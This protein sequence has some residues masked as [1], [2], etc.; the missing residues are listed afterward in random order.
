MLPLKPKTISSKIVTICLIDCLILVVLILCLVRHSMIALEEEVIED[1]LETDLAY[2]QCKLGGCENQNWEIRDGYLYRGDVRLGNGVEA[3]ANVDPFMEFEKE[4]GTFGFSGL[5]VPDNGLHRND[6]TGNMQGHYLR[7]AGSTKDPDG[8][9]II[10]TYVDKYV[11][12]GLDKEGRFFGNSNVE[13]GMIYSLY[14]A[15]YNSKHEITGFVVVGRAASE[16]YDQVRFASQNILVLLIIIILLAGVGIALVSHRWTKGISKIV[17]YLGR[18]GQNEFPEDK[19]VVDSRDETEDIAESINDMV[20][21]LKTGKRIGVELSLASDIQAHM[22]PCIFPPY[23]DANEFDVFASMTPAKEVGG[24][25]YDFF[26]LD[27]KNIAVVIADVSGKGIPSALVMVIAKTLIKNH[28]TYGLEPAEVFTTVNK[29]LC[30]GNDNCMFVTA[31]MGVLNTE[32]GKLTYVNAGHN[33]PLIKKADGTFEYLTSKAEFVLAGMEGI[34]YR[35]NVLLMEPGSRLFLYTDGV[36]EATNPQEELYGED[37]L[38]DFLNQHSTEKPTELL[39][40]LKKNIDAFA[41]E[42]EQF[43]DMTMLVLDYHKR[44]SNRVDA[45]EKTFPA[46]VDVLPDATAFLEEELEKLECSS[47]VQMQLSIA[48]EELFVNIAHYAY[49]GV[50]GSVRM[51]ISDAGENVVIQ[52]VDSGIPFNPLDKEDPNITSSAEEREIGGLGIFLAKKTADGVDYEY[53]NGQNILTMT[54]KKI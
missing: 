45:S 33:H 8:K 5:R 50:R 30:E 19:L 54:K 6:I 27:E 10:G 31:W 4:T 26:M 22:L 3:E 53:K 48:L 29:M 14:Y 32:T 36:T 1:R 51:S 2:L 41:G 47:K 25:F 15:T 23:P 9:S 38:R 52:L 35:Q 21:A 24:D 17:E 12:D 37:R 13:G 43:D 40:L 42:A 7:I 18:V 46:D 16:L 11:A 44:Y 28:T 34:R 20:N 39:S 49:P